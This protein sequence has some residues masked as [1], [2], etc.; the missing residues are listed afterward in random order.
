MKNASP[1]PGSVFHFIK[2]FYSL[3]FYLVL[4]VIIRREPA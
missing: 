3:I 1:D 2:S 4:D